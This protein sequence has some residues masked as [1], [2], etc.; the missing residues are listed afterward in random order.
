MSDAVEA[1]GAFSLALADADAGTH[2]AE[3]GLNI[4]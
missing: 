3:L 1:A 4:T 2:G